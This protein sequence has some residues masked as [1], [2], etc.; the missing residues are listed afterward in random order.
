MKKLLIFMLV[1]GM[2]TA[3][4]ATPVLSGSSTIAPGDT[5]TITVS[6]TSDEASQSDDNLFPDD[7]TAAYGGSIIVDRAS[8]YYG[9]GTTY[10]DAVLSSPSVFTANVGGATP[11]PSTAPYIYTGYS[12]NRIDFA[13]G[14]DATWSEATDIDAGAWFTFDL[15]LDSGTSLTNGTVIPVD[16]FTGGNGDSVEQLEITVTIVPEPM[17]IALLGLGGLFL[18]RRK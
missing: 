18:R 9:P 14:S 5:I 11:T 8:H 15:T 17:T 7:V 16:L 1:L 10:A 2:A 3:A 6:G 12:S 13:A 4:S